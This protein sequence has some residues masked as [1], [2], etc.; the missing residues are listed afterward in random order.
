MS[1][2][3]LTNKVIY[4]DL[5]MSFDQHPITDDVA[6]LT[7][8]MS[9]RQS[10]RTLILTDTGERLMQPNLGGNIRKM[11][12][13]NYTPQ[14]IVTAESRIRNLINEEEPRAL[15]RDVIISSLEDRNSVSIQIIYSTVNRTEPVSMEVVLER[16]R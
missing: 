8:E 1:R 10:I 9:V 5:L 7:N 12:F 2:S 4:S 11:L 13:E 14:T 15:L 16:V 3:P 6:L